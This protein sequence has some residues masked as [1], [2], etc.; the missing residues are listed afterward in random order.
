[1]K[2]SIYFKE[3]NLPH[4]HTDIKFMDMSKLQGVEIKGF[5]YTC[6]M[7]GGSIV[8]F[9]QDIEKSV[10][11]LDKVPYIAHEVVHAL[12]IICERLSAKAENEIEHLAY[13]MTYVLK[14][15]QK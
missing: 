3:I 13:I 7:E 9:I 14:E 11:E 8:I 4:I 15:L 6:E 1:M 5:G 10:K 12:Q 2:K